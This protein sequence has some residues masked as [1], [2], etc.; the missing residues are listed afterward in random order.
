MEGMGGRDI[1]LQMKI[2]A[3][4]LIHN[5]C[6]VLYCYIMRSLSQ[7]LTECRYNVVGYL[8][9]CLTLLAGLVVF[10]E[11]LHRMHIL[12]TLLAFCGTCVTTLSWY[13][14]T[15]LCVA[16][17]ICQLQQCNQSYSL[18]VMYYNNY[19]IPYYIPQYGQGA[20]GYWPS[21]G[22]LLHL[23]YTARR[24]VGH[25]NYEPP[26]CTKCNSPPINGQCT[27][28][29]II[30]CGT[31]YFSIFPFLHEICRTPIGLRGTAI[32]RPQE[33]LSVC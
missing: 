23:V 33:L 24:G 32:D 13:N 29:H 25:S 31:L 22:G 20:I 18:T 11:H 15:V 3:T 27:G 8:K 16:P 14:M 9:F 17:L 30:R 7:C 28:L 1:P 6:D 4:V 10:N 5:Q 2:L 12:G 26:R 19:Y 21:M